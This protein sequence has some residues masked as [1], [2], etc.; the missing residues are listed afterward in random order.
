V[1]PVF[2]SRD[3]ELARLE[4]LFGRAVDGRGQVCFI[5]GEAGFG[6]TSLM[7]EFARRAQRAHADVLV[8]IG[9]CNAQTGISDPYLPFREIL[10]MLTGDVD[11]RVATGMT[12]VEN[13]NRLQ[14]FLRVSKQVITEV[15]PDLIGIFIPGAGV[16][17]RAGVVIAGDLKR[18]KLGQGETADQVAS[19]ASSPVSPTSVAD[20]SRIFEQLT[21]VFIEL[22]KKRPLI[23][24][25]DDLHWIDESS[26]SLLFHLAR[27][28]ERSRILVIGTYRPEDVAVGRGDGSH[29]LPQ[30]VS[31]LKSH[32]GDL[33]IALGDE[34]RA[35]TRQFVDALIDAAPNRLGD[36]F[37]RELHQRTNGHA[38]FAT[39]LLQTMRERGDLVQD[40]SGCWIQQPTLDWT[41][42]PARVEGVIEERIRRMR[43]ELQE[44]LTIA[45]VEGETFTVQVV[46]P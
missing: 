16:A 29:P 3:R 23:L 19:P 1:D 26:A 46:H 5:T 12:T 13:A 15:A 43:K 2:V 34:T 31:E 11:E 21:S 40:A 4:Q 32:Y 37:R 33:L 7:L 44:I 24:V 28:I 25:L 45:S 41:T 14:E 18:R 10:A 30:V 17:A 9:D 20:Q 6:K 8:A 35:E 27:R 36:A 22:A 38:L 42:I 39:E